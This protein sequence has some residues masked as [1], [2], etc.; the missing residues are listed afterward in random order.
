MG[1]HSGQKYAR[2]RSPGAHSAQ[3]YARCARIYAHSGSPDGVFGRLD[4]HRWSK[5]DSPGGAGHE[6][7]PLWR[8]CPPSAC[9]A[10]WKRQPPT[11]NEATILRARR[12]FPTAAEQP[13]M[14]LFIQGRPESVGAL[15]GG[16]SGTRDWKVSPPAGWKAGV[17]GRV[18]GE[19][20]SSC[21]HPP[22]ACA[23]WLA[24]RCGV[25][26]G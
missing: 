26:P 10:G 25:S 18:G 23:G 19:F 15:P 3:K 5:C 24:C 14:A 7:H 16:R 8:R 6:N 11:P 9:G 1:A 21:N 13:P 20:I 22:E 2:S 4:A 17:T 12:R